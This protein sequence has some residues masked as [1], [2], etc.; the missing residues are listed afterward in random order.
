MGKTIKD[1]Y[2]ALNS[3]VETQPTIRPVMDLTDIQNGADEIGNM[4]NG[5]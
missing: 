4:M 3:D 5:A 1:I 2:D